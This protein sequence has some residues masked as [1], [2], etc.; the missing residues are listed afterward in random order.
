MFCPN[1]QCFSPTLVG[2][3]Q[4]GDAKKLVI[5]TDAKG[6][7]AG[8]SFAVSYADPCNS[9]VYATV[10]LYGRGQKLGN[11]MLKIEDKLAGSPTKGRTLQAEPCPTGSPVFR[12]S[13]P[14]P[15]AVRNRSWQRLSVQRS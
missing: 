6:T 15:L 3:N 8:G 14:C 13:A 4:P 7:D 10:E 1:P 2:Y 12:W 5:K 11:E 9:N